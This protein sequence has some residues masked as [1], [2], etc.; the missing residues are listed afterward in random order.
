[1]RI[2]TMGLFY[3]AQTQH[4]D[5]S[6]DRLFKTLTKSIW[7]S[8]KLLHK[9]TDDEN[10]AVSLIVCV[11]WLKYRRFPPGLTQWDYY[12]IGILSP[13]LFLD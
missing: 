1:M 7:C 12:G 9:T 6:V 10:V 8:P 2:I 5:F 13:I 4:W 11:G 3:T